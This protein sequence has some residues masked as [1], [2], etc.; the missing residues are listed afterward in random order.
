MSDYSNVV[1]VTKEKDCHNLF[2]QIP[3]FYCA[4][5]DMDHS[6]FKYFLE[7]MSTC[8]CSF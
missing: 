1:I 3:C 7:V 4:L 5:F 8:Y 6:S 2:S